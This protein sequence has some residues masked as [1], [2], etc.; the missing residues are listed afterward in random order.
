M[1]WIII[2]LAGIW[3]IVYLLPDLIWHHLQWKAA[4]GARDSHQI[5]LTFDD[6]PGP[7]TEIILQVL[8]AHGAHATFFVVAER[9]RHYPEV[10]R[11]MVR[12][13]HEIGLHGYQHR[14]MYLFW[15]WAVKSELQQGI[16]TIEQIAGV[17]PHV[18]RPPWGHHNLMTGIMAQRLGLKRVLWTIAP[19]DWKPGKT[20]DI[21]DRYV[22]QLSS[23][24]AIVVMHDAGGER[25]ATVEALN[26]SIPQVRKLGMEPV[27]ISELRP[28]T[29]E[30]RRWW[31]WWETRFTRSWD[32]DTIPSSL[33]GDP[34]L[35]LGHIR[36]PYHNTALRSGRT[37]RRGD[38]MGEI[39]FGNPAL[40][41]LSAGKAG[42]LRAYHAVLRS[43]SDLAQYVAEND[44]Y[45]DITVIGGITLLDA[46]NAIE[47]LGFDRIAV[48]GIRKWSMWFYLMFLMAIYHSD[49]WS[50][51]KRFLKLHPVLLMMD[52]ETL[53]KKYLRAP[54]KRQA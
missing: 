9:A 12:D 34:V 50:T 45:Q 29:S 38:G 21:I 40:S 46:S 31:T 6:G 15:P 37:I 54:T 20:V 53:M 44:K 41:Q 35:R 22:T 10:L 47:K 19:D 16:D 24:G 48:S 25:K 39:H 7:D 36:F 32:I 51:F 11:A 30:M 2:L 26:K 18:Y 17:T 52:R 1:E 23:P 33:G 4:L 42:G 27:T 5:A 13:G 28:E 14:S 49:G 8:R 43:L 3:M